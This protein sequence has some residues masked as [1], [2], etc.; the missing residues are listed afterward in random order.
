MAL[1]VVH[2][3]IWPPEVLTGQM[4]SEKADMFSYGMILW[5]LWY[6]QDVM[7]K[8]KVSAA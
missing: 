5:E 7:E 6:G 1:Y 3:S 4:Y 2:L 8:Y